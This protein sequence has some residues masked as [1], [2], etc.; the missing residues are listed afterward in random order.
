[1]NSAWAQ[2]IQGWLTSRTHLCFWRFQWAGKAASVVLCSWCNSAA[3]DQ[4]M[5]ATPLTSTYFLLRMSRVF[6]ILFPSLSYLL[7]FGVF[8]M[9]LMIRI[10]DP[11]SRLRLEWTQ[12]ILFCKFWGV[13]ESAPWVVDFSFFREV[14]GIQAKDLQFAPVCWLDL[15]E[16]LCL[17]STIPIYTTEPA[18][19][20]LIMDHGHIIQL[21]F[22]CSST[23]SS[24]RWTTWAVTGSRQQVAANHHSAFDVTV[25]FW[26]QKEGLQIKAYPDIFCLILNEIQHLIWSEISGLKKKWLGNF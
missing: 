24:G 25:R 8:L 17:H 3:V 15:A 21:V 18:H 12:Q 26:Y 5:M 7:C 14:E 6:F 22:W 9:T 20:R 23:V 4:E 2:K 13:S 11:D 1:M 16:G 19:P 10:H